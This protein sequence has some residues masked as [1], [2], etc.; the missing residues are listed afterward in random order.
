MTDT[1]TDPKNEPHEDPANAAP[2]AGDVGL[3]AVLGHEVVAVRL[4]AR[5]DAE[6]DEPGRIEIVRWRGAQ[7]Y[8]PIPTDRLYVWAR[9]G[10]VSFGSK[11]GRSVDLVLLGEPEMEGLKLGDPWPKTRHNPFEERHGNFA[12]LVQGVTDDLKNV[13]TFPSSFPRMMKTSGERNRVLDA[14]VGWCNREIPGIHTMRGWWRSAEGPDKTQ[15]GG[16]L[17]KGLIG[18]HGW[19]PD[20]VGDRPEGWSPFRNDRNEA[21]GSAR[22]EPHEHASGA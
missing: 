5:G 4:V 3:P 19:L 1:H 6:S 12:N 20:T 11:S 8:K 14:L 2:V 15:V 10:R 16:V 21:G 17:H 22:R 7:V 13:V 9:A 18:D